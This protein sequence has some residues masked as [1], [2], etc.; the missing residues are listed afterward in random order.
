MNSRYIVTC[1]Q[2]QV[3]LLLC[4]GNESKSLLMQGFET[5]VSMRSNVS[6]IFECN[7]ELGV[8]ACE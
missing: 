7:F 5:M 3:L 2:E 4:A 6:L 8:C 1:F